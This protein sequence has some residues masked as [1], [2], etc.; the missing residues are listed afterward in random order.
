MTLFY[1]AHVKHT[2]LRAQERMAQNGTVHRT[3]KQIEI[4]QKWRFAES[5]GDVPKKARA[6]KS[7]HECVCVWRRVA[8]N[9]Q[10][11][12]REHTVHRTGD[13]Q[14]GH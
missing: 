11:R 12:A 1:V 4:R 3:S 2:K 8:R 9:R 10:E 13:A 5:T 6:Y 14:K 7:H